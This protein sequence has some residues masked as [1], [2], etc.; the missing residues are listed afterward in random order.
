MKSYIDKLKTDTAELNKQ[1]QSALAK[2]RSADTRVSPDWIPLTEQIEALMRSLPTAQ[3]DRPWSMEELCLR[4]KG[5]FKSNPHPMHVGHALRAL[6][7]TS[8]RDW[9][10]SGGGRRVWRLMS[11]VEG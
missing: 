11:A 5:K 2:K 3:R 4:L 8:K 10:R 6:G 1:R 7:W 9:T